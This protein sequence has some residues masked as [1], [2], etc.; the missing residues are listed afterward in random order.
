[1]APVTAVVTQKKQGTIL[2]ES[3]WLSSPFGS[4]ESA[5][6]GITALSKATRIDGKGISLGPLIGDFQIYERRIAVIGAQ[7]KRPK[8][9]IRAASDSEM[10][11]VLL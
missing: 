11:G 3:Y 9:V 5:S 6:A 1:M 7:P 4:N 10:P 8:N 2:S